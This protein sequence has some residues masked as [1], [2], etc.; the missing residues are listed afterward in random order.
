MRDRSAA[1]PN[2]AFVKIVHLSVFRKFARGRESFRTLKRAVII[3]A[4]VGAV[5]SQPHMFSQLIL[6]REACLMSKAGLLRALEHPTNLVLGS[7]VA[8]QVS[9]L[10]KRFSAIASLDVTEE[11]T[12]MDVVDMRLK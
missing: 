11:G 3:R 6:A 9:L 2:A 7:F 10:S 1:T 8:I 5:L 4:L 12:D